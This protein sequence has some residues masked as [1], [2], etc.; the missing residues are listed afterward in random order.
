MEQAVPS[1]VPVPEAPQS[2]R[3]GERLLTVVRAAEVAGVSE[4][5]LRRYVRSGRVS[6]ERWRGQTMIPA[7][8]AE[9]VRRPAGD[10][11]TD[12]HAPDIAGRVQDLE[13]RIRELEADRDAWKAQ[14][15]ALVLALAPAPSPRRPWWPWSRRA[16]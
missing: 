12:R 11:H 15:Q 3:T 9:R 10:A 2:E 14:A 4:R 8:E 16:G 1:E 6:C 13:A 7:A 5:T